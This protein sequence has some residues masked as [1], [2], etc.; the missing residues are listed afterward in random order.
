M[1]K[2]FRFLLVSLFSLSMWL[3]QANKG[4]G[5]LHMEKNSQ[6]SSVFSEPEELVSDLIAKAVEFKNSREPGD[7][8]TQ[9]ENYFDFSYMARFVLG[10]NVGQ[11][12]NKTQLKE[13][14][15]LFTEVQALSLLPHLKNLDSI[16]LLRKTST[17][18]QTLLKFNYENENNQDIEIG[19][20]V[21]KDKKSRVKIYDLHIE[22][23]RLLLTWRSEFQSVI[24]RQGFDGMMSELRD[25]LENKRAGID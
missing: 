5:S 6:E 15:E 19:I 11:K 14:I 4:E 13:F 20:F 22:G 2:V 1:Y 10:R 24:E 17:K 8:V 25:S 9:L 16:K 21:K 7:F 12:I 3:A 18:D 23:I